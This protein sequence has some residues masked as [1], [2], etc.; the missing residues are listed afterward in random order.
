MKVLLHVNYYEGVNKLDELFRIAQKFGYDG[1]EL[2]WK[3]A[4]D[5]EAPE[6]T[7]DFIRVER[8]SGFTIVG[9]EQFGYYSFERTNERT[10]QLHH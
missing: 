9:I 7:F 4:F 3:Y 2:R 1:V 8:N 5:D 6:P 10:I